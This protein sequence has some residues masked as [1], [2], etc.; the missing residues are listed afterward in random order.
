ML[1]QHLPALPA[2]RQAAAARAFL[3][4]PGAGVAPAEV[5]GLVGEVLA[6]L[7]HPDLAPAFGPGSRAEVPLTGVVEGAVVGGLVDR[8]AVTADAVWVVDYKTD[9]AAPADAAAVPVAYRRQLAAYRAVLA[10]ALPGR[11][12]RSFLVWTVGARVMEVTG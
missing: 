3:S 6:V 7:R 10:A 1:L 2:D 8:L 11:R 4:R 12:V 9:R 5:A